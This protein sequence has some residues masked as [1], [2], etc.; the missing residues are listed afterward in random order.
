M[1][2]PANDGV[3]PPRPKFFAVQRCL[4]P[5][6]G[7]DLRSPVSAQTPSRFGP[8]N[9]GQSSA[10]AVAPVRNSARH[11]T[12][13]FIDRRLSR[14]GRMSGFRLLQPDEGMLTLVP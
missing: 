14:T 8:R 3:P 11:Q 10:T 7:Q 12:E 13:R 4:G 1:T 6:S 9:E 5:P 2:P